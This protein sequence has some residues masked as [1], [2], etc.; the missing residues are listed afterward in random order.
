MTTQYTLPTSIGE[1]LLQYQTLG[2]AVVGLAGAS[3]AVL[4]VLVSHRLSSNKEK[5]NG[6]NRKVQTADNIVS[7]IEAEKQFAPLG[8]MSL[9]MMNAAIE[10]PEI[11]ADEIANWIKADIESN[12]VSFGE[13]MQFWK[14]I[15]EELKGF[16]S[17]I[18][19][20]ISF[21][22]WATGRCAFQIGIA[23]QRGTNLTSTE[24]VEAARHIQLLLYAT[25]IASSHLQ[26]ELVEYS[27][28]P[29][30][31]ENVVSNKG[32]RFGK[33]RLGWWVGSRHYR[34]RVSNVLRDNTPAGEIIFAEEVKEALSRT[35]LDQAKQAV[36]SAR[37]PTGRSVALDGQLPESRKPVPFR[38]VLPESVVDEF[39]GELTQF[40]FKH[41]TEKLAANDSDDKKEDRTPDYVAFFEHLLEL[42]KKENAAAG[43]KST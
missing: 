1:L 28:S 20:I 25:G 13:F 24:L 22:V 11:R 18:S 5:R 12:F 31:Y 17:P 10:V 3:M 34:H 36:R 30:R 15:Y 2:A 16:P 14:Q 35:F 9:G 26:K 23:R 19:D 42:S 29:V 4:A 32:S 33:F 21:V 8:Y 43:H 41:F 40:K 7:L 27:T 39:E 6:I 37:G 38:L